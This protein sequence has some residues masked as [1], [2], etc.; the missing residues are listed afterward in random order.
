VIS[1]DGNLLPRPREVLSFRLG[2]AERADIIVDFAKIAERF[3][4]PSRLHIENRLEQNNGRGPTNNIKPA[5]HGDPLLEFRLTGSRPDDT[6]FDPEPVATPRNACSTGDSVF[7]PITLPNMT[8]ETPRITRHFEFD[9]GDG[10]WQINGRLMDC[11]EPRLR[12]QRNTM[13]R[14]VLRNNAGGWQHPIHIHME[15]FQVVSRNGEP[16]VCGDRDFGRKDV[17]QLRF[18]E[19]VELL[20]RF[21]DYRGVYPLH[22]HNT[23]HEDHQMMLLFDVSDVGDDVTEP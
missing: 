5:G 8:D 7:A 2:V 4:N 12:P 17:I 3:G 9:R 21:R 18:N 19:E 20:M 1:S 6:S 23:V 11:T 22:C 16:V 14:W 15:E 13:E 10:Q